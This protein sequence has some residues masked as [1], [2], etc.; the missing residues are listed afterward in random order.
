[1]SR[2]PFRLPKN[3]ALYM[4][5]A[6]I[7]EGIYLHHKVKFQ[8][9]KVLADLLKEEGL[10]TEAYVEEAKT[11]LLRFAKGIETFMTI[12]TSLQQTALDILQGRSDKFQRSTFLTSVSILAAGLFVGSALVYPHDIWMALGLLL[13]GI[14][15]AAAS[16]YRKRGTL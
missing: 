16:F 10:V 6:S 7:L 15:A 5:M 3:L 12:G 11:S 2:F 1:M 13:G 9:I 14:A 4:R 8:F